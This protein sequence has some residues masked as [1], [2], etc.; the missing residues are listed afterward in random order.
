MGA[1][2]LWMWI[3]H[4]ASAPRINCVFFS[5]YNGIIYILWSSFLLLMVYIL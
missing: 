3:R 5:D 2:L 4:K 1:E